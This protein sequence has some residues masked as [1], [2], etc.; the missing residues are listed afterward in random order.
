VLAGMSMLFAGTLCAFDGIGPDGTWWVALL[1]PGVATLLAMQLVAALER[2]HLQEELTKQVTQALFGGRGTRWLEQGGTRGVWRHGAGSPKQL[3]SAT[4]G[5]GLTAAAEEE[6]PEGEAGEASVP[7][8]SVPTAAE[9]RQIMEQVAAHEAPGA[10][11]RAVTNAWILGLV[12]LLYGLVLLGF[13]VACGRWAADMPYCPAERPPREAMV[14]CGIAI[15]ASEVA[16]AGALTWR[17]STAGGAPTIAQNRTAVIAGT[18]WSILGTAL[19]LFAV[20][21]RPI[22]LKVRCG[23]QPAGHTLTHAHCSP[24]ISGTHTMTGG[25]Y[26]IS[27]AAISEATTPPLAHSTEAGASDTTALT[28]LSR[29]LRWVGIMWP[30]WAGNRRRG[31][32]PRHQAARALQGLLPRPGRVVRVAG[33]RAAD[34]AVAVPGHELHRAKRPPRRWR[35]CARRFQPLRSILT[36]IYLCNTVLVTEYRG[37]KRLD[38]R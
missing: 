36:E 23:G 7:P 8:S 6:E 33:R 16:M 2:L 5:K 3:A 12:V 37:R 26:M 18:I 31:G 38:R 22:V 24:S 10:G 30:V 13:G 11:G 17:S 32:R 27:F 28:E 4:R 9:R 19:V 21:C 1:A 25:D 34:A 14:V 35:R 20:G 15:V 29:R